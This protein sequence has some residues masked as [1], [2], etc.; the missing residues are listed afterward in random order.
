MKTI[1][2]DDFLRLRKLIHRNARPLDYTMWK[3]LFENSGGDDFLGVLSSY[4]NEDGGFG[5]N[6][7]CN[8]WN[9][10]SS[11]YTVCIALDYLDIVEDSISSIKD[12]IVSGIIRY[13]ESGEHMLESGWVGMQGIPSNND[14]AHMPWFHF[15]PGKAEKADIGVT[16]RLS[17]FV[18][19]YADQGSDIYL[20]A[21]GFKDKYRECEQV[22]LEGYP[23]YDPVKLKIQEYD[24]AT[25]PTWL[26]MP[27]Y[28]IGSPQSSYYAGCE[29]TVEMNLDKMVDGLLKTGEPQLASAEDLEAF[30]RSKPHPDG[31]RWC[32]AEQTIGNY[33]WNAHF[34]TRDLNILKKFGRL[35]F[36]LP[37]YGKEL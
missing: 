31:K 3:Y 36:T 11:P 17:D 14:Y 22:L 2:Y 29:H 18:L 33:F 6:I 8:N 7:E 28:F 24:P 13:L 35:D 19:R 16:K 30:E 12:S 32:T 5:H 9:P 20:K 25:W 34:I 27:V 4:Q 23:D 1:S 10:D 26:P 15:K 21:A 37:V